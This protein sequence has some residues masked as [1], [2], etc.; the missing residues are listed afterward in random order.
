MH[1]AQVNGQT[2]HYS[3]TGLQNAPAVVFANSLG[4]DLRLWD[5]ILPLL[6]DGLRVIRFDKRG[7]GLS[8]CPPGPYSIDDLV[9]DAEG[10]LD[11]L[12]VTSCI[13]VGLSIGGQIAQGLAAKRPD[14]IRAMV[15]SNTGAKMGTAQMWGDR[16][17]TI[18][19]GG[20]AAMTEAILDRWF[21]AA[22]RHDPEVAAWGAML[23]RTPKEG[24]LGCCHALAASDLTNSTAALRLPA[25]AICGSEDGASAP[26][27]VQATAALI[28]GC[29]YHEI[30]GAG[31]LPCVEDPAAYTEILNPFLKEHTHG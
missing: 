6:P 2:I 5:P 8:S 11:H 31:H 24:Y 27:L 25:I 30:P 29:T 3:D 22:F 15:L 26:Q 13:F 12:G 17:G 21:G 20:I 23:E 28:P 14:L 18:E 9:S 19:K 7:H 4:T 10:L 1:I 16:I